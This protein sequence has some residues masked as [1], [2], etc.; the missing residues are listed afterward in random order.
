MFDFSL[1]KVI[2]HAIILSGE[3]LI[4]IQD[5]RLIMEKFIEISEHADVVLCCRISPK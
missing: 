2:D 1:N 4:F 5:D 3:S